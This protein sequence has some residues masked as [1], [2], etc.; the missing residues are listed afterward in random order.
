MVQASSLRTLNYARI[1]WGA[2]RDE[3]QSPPEVELKCSFVKKKKRMYVYATYV[4]M[5]GLSLY[6]KRVLVSQALMMMYDDSIVMKSL[7]E[8]CAELSQLLPAETLS[9]SDLTKKKVIK[10][11][12]SGSASLVH[13]FVHGTPAGRSIA[14]GAKRMGTSF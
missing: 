12:T 9:G 7:K 3:P 14:V 4:V 13:F 1:R 6:V 8:Q 2:I 5:V 11:V 10:R